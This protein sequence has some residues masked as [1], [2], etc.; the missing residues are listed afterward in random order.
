MPVITGMYTHMH[1][2]RMLPGTMAASGEKVRRHNINGIDIGSRV[3][4]QTADSF[5]R[6]WGEPSMPFSQYPGCVPIW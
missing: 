1:I 4:K 5:I 6:Q 2:E 3:K